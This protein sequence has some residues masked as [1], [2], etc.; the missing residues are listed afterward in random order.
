MDEINPCHLCIVKINSRENLFVLFKFFNKKIN[1]K[2]VDF[3]CRNRHK[4]KLKNNMWL[5]KCNY[6]L[7]S[8]KRQ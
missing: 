8:I 5:K 3:S 7:K 4:F 6:L 2:I 1:L